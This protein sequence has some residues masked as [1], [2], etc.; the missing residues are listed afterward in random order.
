MTDSTRPFLV[1]YV[2]WHP[3]F[4]DG[5]AIAEILRQHFRRKLYENI[6]GGTGLSVI[7]RYVLAPES[8]QPLPID[9]ADA[10]TSAIV[11]LVDNNLVGDTAWTA[12]V[13]ELCRRTEAAGLGTRVFPV[14]IDAG[15]LGRLGTNEQAL[16]WARWE[17]ELAERGRRLTAALTYAFCRLLRHYLEH[18]KRP[19]EEEEALE[20]YLKKVRIFLSHS[21]HDRHGEDIARNVRSRLHN[22]PG[23]DSFFDVYDIPAGLRFQKIL[24]HNVRVSA[25]VAIHTDSYSSREWCRKEIIE[26]KRWHVP[27]VVANS[28]SDI[29][30]RG[31]PY[32][33]NVPVV[34]LEPDGADR[35]DFVIARLLDE[36]L[37][38]FLWRCRIALELSD[39]NRDPSVIFVP[40]PP[41]LIS[42]ASLP[43]EADVP[44]PVIVYPDPPLSAEEER[45][46]AEISPRV[47]LR[48]LTEWKA[49]AVR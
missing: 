41:E 11:V 19:E 5:L 33:G 21:K 49:G 16:L 46:F 2:V 34:R 4:S 12:Y 22:T 27:L 9:L 36:V 23:M 38:D 28:I 45:L 7:Y 24:I 30:E 6:A 31:F 32:M 29:D 39:E 1:V 25:M 48:S 40:R 8:T 37:K 17:G 35:I 10:D 14:E 26:A 44:N 15:V 43:P 42:L 13:Q 18:L 3:A 20:A 47:Q